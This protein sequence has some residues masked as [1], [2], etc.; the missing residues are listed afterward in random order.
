MDFKAK[1]EKLFS[2]KSYYSIIKREKETFDEYTVTLCRP[3]I[4]KGRINSSNSKDLTNLRRARRNIVEILRLNLNPFSS[5][6]TL[7]YREN[8]QDYDKAYEDF[9]KFVMRLKTA[10][11]EPVQYLQVKELQKR[12]A[13]HF[14]MVIFNAKFRELPYKRVYEIWRHGAVHIKPIDDFD[15][16]TPDRIGNYLGAYLTKNTDEIALSKRIYS[17]SR[18]LKRIKKVNLTSFNPYKNKEMIEELQR[19]ATF[20]IDGARLKKFILKKDLTHE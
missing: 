8:V 15:S 13:I 3:T 11:K 14:H 2:Q 9:K 1:T 12:G 6:V 5:F 7:T 4:N 20:I 17:T 10:L 19:K 16:T 18:G